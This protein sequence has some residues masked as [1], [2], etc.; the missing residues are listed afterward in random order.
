MLQSFDVWK[1]NDRKHN[2]L[3]MSFKDLFI[4]HCL[5]HAL[6][7]RRITSKG[8]VLRARIDNN[9]LLKAREKC[10]NKASNNSPLHPTFY[11]NK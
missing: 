6:N 7:I 3:N 9:F 2:K 10:K 1:V 4:V 8:F 5:G 11:I